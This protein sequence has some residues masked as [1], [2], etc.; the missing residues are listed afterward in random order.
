MFYRL[1]AFAVV[2]FWL[3]E[4]DVRLFLSHIKLAS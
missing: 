4:T 2:A 3:L 1:V